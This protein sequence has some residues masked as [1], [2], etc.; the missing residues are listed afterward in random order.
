MMKQKITL[1]I[2]SLLTSINMTYGS[3]N[4]YYYYHKYKDMG[5]YLSFNVYGINLETGVRKLVIKAEDNI[6]NPFILSDH[7]KILFECQNKVCVY[8]HNSE[9]VDTL[10]HLGSIEEIS[11]VSL[12]PL[13]NEIYLSIVK[14]GAKVISK[15]FHEQEH[16]YLSIDKNTYTLIDTVSTFAI[17]KS[18][19][20]RDG[21]KIYKL[22]ESTEGIYFEGV[23]LKTGPLNF[24]IF[25]I[26]DYE[27]LQM[28]YNPY[29][30]DSNNGY[31]FIGYF[32][33][34]DDNWHLVLCDPENKTGISQITLPTAIPPYA[35]A[36]SK[37]GDLIFQDGGIIYIFD[38]I[39]TTLKQR[40]RFQTSDNIDAESKIVILSDNIYFFPEDP[41]KSD[42]TSFDNIGHA[43]LTVIQPDISLI[44]MLIDDVDES[45]QNGW[46]DNQGIANSLNQKLENAKKQ[47][48]KGK[49]KQAV[50]ILNAFINEVEAQ[51]DKHLTSEVYVLLKY[52][53]EYLIQRL[54]ED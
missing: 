19:I 46:V 1:I 35:K 25:P 51:K 18:V 48:E 30:I 9:T 5:G 38:G 53:A 8:D 13:K 3:D 34:I 54:E 20:S 43:D 40:L 7:I 42:A 32:S 2:L 29:I 44:E 11:N 14:M 10:S 52:N 41:E 12:I 50:N 23:I 15:E 33:E 39:T 36:I 17:I 45:Y 27:N 16:T 28:K 31:A 49:T 26:E 24:N 21:E 22:H 47:L 4:N 6:G 37:N